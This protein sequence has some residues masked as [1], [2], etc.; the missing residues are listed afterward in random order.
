M[1]TTGS[2]FL[3]GLSRQFTSFSAA[4]NE[5]ALSRIYGGIH[6]RSATEDGLKAGLDIGEWTF[7][8]VMRP[9]G[10]HSR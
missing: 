2:D 1:F 8:H 3:P 5:A 9:K 7:S 4:A 6:F 10:N